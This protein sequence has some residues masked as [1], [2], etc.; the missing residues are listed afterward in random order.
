VE[1]TPIGLNAP[2]LLQALGQMLMFQPETGSLSLNLAVTKNLFQAIGGKLTVRQ[3]AEQGE[4]L[5]IFLPLEQ[6]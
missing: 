4:V 5:T 1:T 3:K 2:P 6:R